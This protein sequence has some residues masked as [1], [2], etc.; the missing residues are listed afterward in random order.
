[1]FC[2]QLG[3][4][5][6]AHAGDTGNAID[7]NPDQAQLINDLCRWHAGFGNDL[8]ILPKGF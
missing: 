4:S 1:M 5:L 3:S 7:R 6:G 2:E 8:F